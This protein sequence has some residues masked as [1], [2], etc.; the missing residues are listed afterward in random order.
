LDF[1]LFHL[2]ASMIDNVAWHALRSY[3]AV[4]L[5][6]LFSK[7]FNEHSPDNEGLRVLHGMAR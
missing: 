5:H 4:L 7:T 2:I 6:H 1:R 3:P